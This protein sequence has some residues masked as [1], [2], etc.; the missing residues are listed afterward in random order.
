MTSSNPRAELDT[1]SWSVPVAALSGEDAVTLGLA[2]FVPCEVPSLSVWGRGACFPCRSHL[3][4]IAARRDNGAGR[5][6]AE[7]HT[8]DTG[9]QAP[10]GG[11][12]RCS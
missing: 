2:P 5:P 4:K 11:H 6:A 12:L 8:A 7:I 3:G 10:V 1:M 9:L